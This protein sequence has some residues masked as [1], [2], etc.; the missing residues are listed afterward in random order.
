MDA[1]AWTNDSVFCPAGE[2]QR[3]RK[4]HDVGVRRRPRLSHR[5][6]ICWSRSRS[7]PGWPRRALV[8]PRC[9]PRSPGTRAGRRR[10]AARRPAA[11]A[12]PPEL[13]PFLIGLAAGDAAALGVFWIIDPFAAAPTVASAPPAVTMWPDVPCGPSPTCSRPRF[14]WP[15]AVSVAALR[16]SLLAF[17]PTFRRRRALGALRGS[18]RCRAGGRG[19]APALPVRAGLMPEIMG[20][21]LVLVRERVPASAFPETP[22]ASDVS[23]AVPPPR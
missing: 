14:R 5:S 17:R 12:L 11:K 3:C 8:A 13:P 21:P 16:R 9:W 7:R 6:R 23:T 1:G 18:S 10:I 22:T 4:W 2:D 20:Q 15:Q 19:T